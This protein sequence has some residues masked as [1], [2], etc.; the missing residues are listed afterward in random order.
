MP[1]YLVA[2]VIEPEERS[3]LDAA[4]HGCCRA[5]HAN[6]VRE[7][8]R[9]VRERP[10]QA[11][12]LSPRCLPRAEVPGVAALVREFPAVPAVAIV[13]RH[14]AISSERLLDL[15]AS[16]VRRVVDLSGRKGWRELRDL[17]GEPSSP[18][19]ARM[20]AK[21]IPELG[22]PSLDCRR[23]FDVLLRHAPGIRSV[24]SLTA[25]L[26]VRP[27]TFMSRFLRAG[28]VSP[29]RYLSAARIVHAAALFEMSGLSV[30]DVAYR[31]EYSSPQSFGRHLRAVTGLTA[32][33]FRR[34]YPFAVALKDFIARM[35]VP[36]RATF[37]TFHPL[38]NGV[39]DHGHRR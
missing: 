27:S 10:V 14:D 30:T 20:L 2:T 36:F 33:E 1:D 26:E 3:R 32:S 6:S 12:L 15:G 38:S 25:W 8:L 17:V 22:E 37:R 29:K 21:V 7:V 5:L 16:G 28:L 24:R 23:F 31:L 11:V 13:S 35:I 39:A 34:R 19:G 4:V 18:I 9:T